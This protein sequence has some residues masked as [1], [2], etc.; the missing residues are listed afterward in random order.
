MAIMVN[1]ALQHSDKRATPIL[2]ANYI[3]RCIPGEVDL[4]VEETSRSIQFNRMQAGLLQ[5]EKEKIRFL[6]TFADKKRFRK[7]I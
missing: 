7:R 1:A 6:G 3:S 5:D 2:T 4:H